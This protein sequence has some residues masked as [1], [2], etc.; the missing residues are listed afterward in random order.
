MKVRG[1][2]VC[3]RFLVGMPSCKCVRDVVWDV[4]A[5]GGVLIMVGLGARA[6]QRCKGAKT[7]S[8]AA[9][10][11]WACVFWGCCGFLVGMPSCTCVL[12]IM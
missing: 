2:V 7:A 3:C 12:D 6:I 4:H 9:W 10:I 5:N 8:C 1:N 11:P